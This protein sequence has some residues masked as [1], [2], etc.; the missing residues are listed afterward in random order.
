MTSIDR[1]G[2]LHRVAAAGVCA[3]VPIADARFR[4]WAM[5]HASSLPGPELYVAVVSDSPAVWHGAELSV[6][7][8]ARSAAMFGGSIAIRAE[9][10]TG[11]PPRGIG[12]IIGGTSLAESRRLAD[13]AHAHD[14]LFMNVGCTD[15]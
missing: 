2:F 10:E 12:V 3:S 9:K 7:E 6:Q 1:R 4:R 15:D 8:S 13:R 5:V 11:H 14:E